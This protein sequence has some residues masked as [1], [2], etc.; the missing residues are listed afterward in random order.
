M[1]QKK[2]ACSIDHAGLQQKYIYAD[3]GEGTGILGAPCNKFSDLPILGFRPRLRFWLQARSSLRRTR[4]H[5]STTAQSD[6]CAQQTK[7][8]DV[9]FCVIL[10]QSGTSWYRPDSIRF[11]ATLL[12]VDFSPGFPRYLEPDIKALIEKIKF[13]YKIMLHR[14]N[15]GKFCTS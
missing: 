3:R 11:T 2:L 15:P 4:I 13:W 1:D 8:P 5:L 12:T 6:E 14:A 9:G 10:F 7:M